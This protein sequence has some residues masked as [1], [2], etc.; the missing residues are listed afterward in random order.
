MPFGLSL[1]LTVHF[2][3]NIFR[4]FELFG[5]GCVILHK[6]KLFQDCSKALDTISKRG[7]FPELFVILRRRTGR[8]EDKL[9]LGDR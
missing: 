3:G 5:E 1:E 2:L 7:N 9:N 6:K 4:I 8:G